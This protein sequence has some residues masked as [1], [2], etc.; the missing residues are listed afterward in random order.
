MDLI[1]FVIITTVLA[2]AVLRHIDLDSLASALGY[3]WLRSKASGKAIACIT[4]PKEDFTLRAEN[5]YALGLAGIN[6]P[7]EELLCHHKYPANIVAVIDHHEDEG[8]YKIVSIVLQSFHTLRT[9][10]TLAECYFDRYPWLK[11]GGIALDVDREAAAFLIPQSLLAHNEDVSASLNN[12]QNYP[13][14]FLSVSVCNIG[15]EEVICIPPQH[16]GLD[17]ERLQ[18]WVLP[19]SHFA[20]PYSLHTHYFPEPEREGKAGAILGAKADK[21][22]AEKVW[23]GLKSSKVLE[24]TRLDLSKVAGRANT[25]EESEG[26]DAE[27]VTSDEARFGESYVARAYKQGNESVTRKQTAPILRRLMEGL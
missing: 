9:F 1:L 13:S 18:R 12:Q 17:A 27:Q 19:P 16:A 11:N 5:L 6:Y 21:G 3:T 24:L 8:Q 23:Q 20:S 22:I 25:A 10:D 7:F 4:T 15:R 14:P 26:E 2:T